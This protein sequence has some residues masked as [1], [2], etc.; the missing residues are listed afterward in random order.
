M[1]KARLQRKLGKHIASLRAERGLSQVEFG[2]LIEMQKQ[3]I[4][5]LENGKSNPTFYTLCKIAIALD[6]PFSAILN[7]PR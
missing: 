5:R 7:F 6:L 2:Y 3:N 1:D 4:N